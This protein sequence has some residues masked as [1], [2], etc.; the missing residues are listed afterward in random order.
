MA[1]EVAEHYGEQWSSG[2]YGEAV[3]SGVG[4]DGDPGSRRSGDGD[5]RHF[6]AQADKVG[7]LGDAILGGD[8]GGDQSAGVLFGRFRIEIIFGEGNFGIVD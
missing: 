3:G 6:G 2:R 5:W 8:Q 4:E 7:L 1:L